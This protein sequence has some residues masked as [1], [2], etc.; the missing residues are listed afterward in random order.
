MYQLTDN[1]AQLLAF[2][3]KTGPT[4]IAKLQIS[5]QT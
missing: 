1:D 4:E 5:S 2:I 3:N